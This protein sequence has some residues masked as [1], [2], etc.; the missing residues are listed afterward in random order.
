MNITI[1][2]FDN[3][4][5]LDVFGPVEIF[6]RLPEHF[7]IAYYSLD[8]GIKTSTQGVEINT[9][10]LTQKAENTDILLIPGGK[11]TRTEVDNFL[12]TDALTKLAVEARY[13]LTVCTGSALLA[14]THLMDGKIATSNKRAFEWVQSVRPQVEWKRKAR[15][16]NQGKYYTSSGISAGMDMA[17]GFL[18]DI[19]NLEVAERIAREMEYNWNSDKENDP[20]A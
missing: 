3:F 1:I 4:E 13:V 7:S 20:F 10:K 11:G 12:L 17:L 19:L 14:T 2:L 6:G 18:S 8:G 5:T 15:W 16:T 9:G